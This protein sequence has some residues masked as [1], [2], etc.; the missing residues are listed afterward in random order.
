MTPGSDSWNRF[1]FSR[2]AY[3]IAAIAA[4]AGVHGVVCSGHEIAR[5]RA[6]QGGRLALLVPGIRLSGDDA[7]DQSR[8]V[9]P[10]VADRAG[11]TYIV[12]GRTVTGAADPRVAMLRVLQELN[13]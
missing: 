1:S 4:E 9:T 8:V 11:A 7:N 3:R 10:S 13:G 2:T 6:E 12:L 5:L